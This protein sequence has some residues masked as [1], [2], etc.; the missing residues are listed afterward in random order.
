MS[1]IGSEW[2]L[3]IPGDECR[4]VIPTSIMP[5]VAKTLETYIKVLIRPFN[6]PQLPGQQFFRREPLSIQG[7]MPWL[8]RTLPHFEY[9]RHVDIQ[10]PI[11][12]RDFHILPAMAQGSVNHFS[13]E[14]SKHPMRHIYPMRSTSNIRFAGT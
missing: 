2:F 11:E 5:G 13:Y 10:F 14:V 4:A 1:V 7:T 8:N 12:L 6:G 3:P 9:S